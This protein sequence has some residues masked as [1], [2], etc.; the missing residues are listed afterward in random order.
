[1]I[2][3]FGK[4]VVDPTSGICSIA[5][6]SSRSIGTESSVAFDCD[7]ADLVERAGRTGVADLGVALCCFVAVFFLRALAVEGAGVCVAL[8]CD[9]DF[10]LGGLTLVCT[11]RKSSL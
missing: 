9:V 1:M 5:G 8:F 7:L 11:R 10:G 3:E 4:G 2:W 6:V